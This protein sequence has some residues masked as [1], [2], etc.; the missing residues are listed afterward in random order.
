MTESVVLW[1]GWVEFMFVL[2]L[3]LR[4]PSND[5]EYPPLRGV[6]I[7]VAHHS[8][9]VKPHPRQAPPAAVATVAAVAAVAALLSRI[10]AECRGI[11]GA[12]GLDG[13]GVLPTAWKQRGRK[14]KP[15]YHAHA[16]GRRARH[17]CVSVRL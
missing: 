11:Q 5:G 14:H 6:G 3:V 4:V 8:N 15:A 17:L 10:R 12:G 13:S 7:S 16:R 2:G 1:E 9:A